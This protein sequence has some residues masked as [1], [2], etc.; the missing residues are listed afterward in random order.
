MNL[1]SYICILDWVDPGHA[2]NSAAHAGTILMLEW[3]DDPILW[4]WTESSIRKTTCEV[5]D[6]QFKYLKRFEDYKIITEIAFGGKEVGMV[7]KP[8]AEWPKYFKYLKL[9][10]KDGTKTS[11]T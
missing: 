7:F 2:I 8:R 1:K 9:W 11:C 4:E 10:G 3:R 5:T 6:D